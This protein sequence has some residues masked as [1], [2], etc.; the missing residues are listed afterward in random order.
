MG[1][2]TAPDGKKITDFASQTRQ[3]FA[4]DRSYPE[5]MESKQKVVQRNHGVLQL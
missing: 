1:G 2:T 3:A 4:L 5:H